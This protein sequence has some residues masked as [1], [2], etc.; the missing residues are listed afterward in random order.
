MPPGRMERSAQARAILARLAARRFGRPVPAS[1]LM[2]ALEREGMTAEAA[3][4]IMDELVA[5]RMVYESDGGFLPGAPPLRT[6]APTEVASFSK[7]HR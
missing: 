6:R 4:A 7:L 1:E 5:Q 3:A 2:D